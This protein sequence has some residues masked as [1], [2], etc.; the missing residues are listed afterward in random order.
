M[1]IYGL[2]LIICA[3]FYSLF[4]EK[5][6]KVQL[7]VICIIICAVVLLIASLFTE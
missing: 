1:W 7:C 3:I 4:I 5:N 6:E 2:I